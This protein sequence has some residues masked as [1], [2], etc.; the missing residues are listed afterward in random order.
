LSFGVR[1]GVCGHLPADICRCHVLGLVSRFQQ[2]ISTVLICQSTRVMNSS[3]S[4]QAL[5]GFGPILASVTCNYKRQ[6]KFPD[7]V[8]IGTKVEKLGISS[9]TLTH[10]IFSQSNNAVS[11][12]GKSVIVM[13]D[14]EAQHPVAIADE[15]REI[16]EKFEETV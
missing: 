14:Y 15:F 10:D 8:L 1:T 7:T 4:P 2:P 6:I 13:F 9:V 12:T 11:A 16:F 3:S 5:N